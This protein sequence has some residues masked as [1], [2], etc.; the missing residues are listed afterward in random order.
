MEYQHADKV[1]E[2]NYV[3]S[4]GEESKVGAP[5]FMMEFCRQFPT[6]NLFDP[7][8]N[9]LLRGTMHKELFEI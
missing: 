8:A 7:L 2:H 6:D 4:N 1:N 3:A 9:F 5:R